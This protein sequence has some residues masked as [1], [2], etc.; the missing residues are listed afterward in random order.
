MPVALAEKNSDRTLIWSG[1]LIGSTGRVVPPLWTDIIIEYH[2][3]RT[4]C[5]GTSYMARSQKPQVIEHL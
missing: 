2:P 3:L 4:E 5:S 1:G